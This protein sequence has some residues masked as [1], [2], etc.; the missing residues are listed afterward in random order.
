MKCYNFCCSRL[1]LRVIYSNYPNL[2]TKTVNWHYGGL[3]SAYET[4]KANNLKPYNYFEYLLTEI[5]NHM[6]E[7]DRSFLKDLLPWSPNLPEHIRK[8]K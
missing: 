7:T 3:S 2:T 1:E 5:P 6:E 4:A 8:P